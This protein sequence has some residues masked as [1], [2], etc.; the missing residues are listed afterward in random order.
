MLNVEREQSSQ[1]DGG[2]TRL[3][4]DL[5]AKRGDARAEEPFQLWDFPLGMEVREKAPTHTSRETRAAFDRIVAAGGFSSAS[6]EG[7][8]LLVIIGLDFGTSST[9]IIIRLPGEPS[10]PTVAIPA[11]DHCRSENHP[12]FWQTVLWT[13]GNGEFISCPEAGANL[14]RA[15]KQGVMGQN[16]DIPTNGATRVE[17]TVAYLSHVI[18]YVRGWLVCN[19]SELFR[20]R[21]VSWLVNLGLPAAGYDNESLVRGY[22]KAAAA[23]LMLADSGGVATVDGARRFLQHERVKG[24]ALSPKRAEELGIAVVPEVAASATSFAKS[25]GSVPGLYLMVDVGAMTLDACTFRLVQGQGG[26]N[27]YPLLSAAVRPLGVEAF[28]WFWE[29]GRTEEEFSTQCRRCLYRIVW[30][31]KRCRDPHAEGFQSGNALP[32]FLAGGG[33]RND[34]HCRII[35]A[36]GPW[37]QQHTGN[38][39]IRLINIP[40]P[41]SIDLPAPLADLNRLVVAWGLSYPPEEIG[42]IK[43]MSNIPDIEPLPH[44]SYTERYVSKDQV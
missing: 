13:R 26:E 44:S 23:A 34:L 1:N 28:H 20:E 18:R 37:L 2:S 11:P 7:R 6:T 27:R 8:P 24:A 42:E 22:R 41:A 4:G 5:S 12:Y 32:V 15:L 36:L 33:S 25:I 38:E 14:L 29:Q 40:T 3:N 31:T 35:D 30:D 16:M 9:K 17:A 21:S 43:P 19:R 39:G 10:E